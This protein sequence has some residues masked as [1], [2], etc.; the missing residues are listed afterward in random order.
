MFAIRKDKE[1]I[2]DEDMESAISKV[3]LNKNSSGTFSEDMFV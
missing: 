3:L 1:Q 2:E